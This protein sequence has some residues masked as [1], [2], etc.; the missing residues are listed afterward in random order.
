MSPQQTSPVVRDASNARGKKNSL[1]GPKPSTP[2]LGC[3]VVEG[4][5][6][7]VFCKAFGVY[8]DSFIRMS[9]ARALFLDA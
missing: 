9:L 7:S 3:F 6:L 4:L 5:S 2:E 8:E 1:Q